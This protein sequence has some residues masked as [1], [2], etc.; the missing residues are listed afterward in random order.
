MKGELNHRIDEDQLHALK[1][2]E[3]LTGVSVDK[4]VRQA[5]GEFI[6]VVL[7][8]NVESFASKASIA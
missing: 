5:L 2:Y 8:T 3:N 1:D 4:L 6:E 7:E